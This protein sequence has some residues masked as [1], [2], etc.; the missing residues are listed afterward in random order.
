MYNNLVYRLPSPLA[1]LCIQRDREYEWDHQAGSTLLEECRLETRPKAETRQSCPSFE[2]SSSFIVSTAPKVL[3]LGL[4][5]PYTV[6]IS[7]VIRK[8]V[9]SNRRTEIGA[10]TLSFDLVG[11]SVSGPTID[12][13]GPSTAP[14]V[15]LQ[16]ISLGI[17]Y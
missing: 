11:D 8:V 1:Y 4:G 6:C 9:L 3:L 2:S 14:N 17:S 13:A 7:D 15:L 10:E 12:L 16:G 5:V